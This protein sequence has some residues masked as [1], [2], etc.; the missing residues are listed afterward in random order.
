MTEVKNGSGSGSAGQGEAPGTAARHDTPRVLDELSKNNTARSTS[1]R[2]HNGL[3][4]FLI[5]V[6]MLVPVVL[7]RSASVPVAVLLVPVVLEKSA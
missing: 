3:R 1:L 6:L 4:R 2:R 7:L 5:I